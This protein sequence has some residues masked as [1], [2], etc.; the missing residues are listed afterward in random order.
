M[1]LGSPASAASS[2]HWRAALCT[3]FDAQLG[4]TRAAI[5]FVKLCPADGPRPPRPAR[6]G[7]C[8]ALYQVVT[9][10]H[11]AWQRTGDADTLME[12]VDR[13]RRPTG[14]GHQTN[15]RPYGQPRQRTAGVLTVVGEVWE[16]L[17]DATHDEILELIASQA[18]K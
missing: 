3:D 18:T 11:G 14:A 4:V 10:E 2:H 1:A 9:E 8:L 12:Y 13:H 15:H 17:T 6:H 5:E 16:F 7:F